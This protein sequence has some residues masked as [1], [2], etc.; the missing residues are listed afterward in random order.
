[1]SIT[2]LHPEHPL[3]KA[4]LDHISVV[5]KL[6]VGLKP[7]DVVFHFAHGKMVVTRDQNGMLM[8]PRR[9]N[10]VLQGVNNLLV[11]QEAKNL[12]MQELDA[13]RKG[14]GCNIPDPQ[15]LRRTGLPR[16]ATR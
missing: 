7:G 11:W 9:E 8:M 3:T 16:I 5:R 12:E 6:D 10:I 4:G 15:Q 14:K 2:K 13:A 1:M